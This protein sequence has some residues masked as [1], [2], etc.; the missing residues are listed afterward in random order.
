[1]ESTP[2]TPVKLLII[3]S[4]AGDLSLKNIQKGL[5]RL[6]LSKEVL[7]SWNPRDRSKVVKRSKKEVIRKILSKQ[8]IHKFKNHQSAY[9]TAKTSSVWHAIVKELYPRKS[10]TERKKLVQYFS[11]A[12]KSRPGRPSTFFSTFI[13]TVIQLH[14]DHCE[15]CPS[16]LS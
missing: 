1:M 6:T 10:A 3:V 4:F 5:V 14:R 11:K 16:Q 12:S 9:T 13:D 7:Q 8:H 2:R 15:R